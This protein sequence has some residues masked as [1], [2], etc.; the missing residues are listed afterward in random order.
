MIVKSLILKLEK[1]ISMVD[2][3]YATC[4]PRMLA[5]SVSGGSSFIS[6]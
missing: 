3:E 2:S 1:P 6:E 4:L 5:P